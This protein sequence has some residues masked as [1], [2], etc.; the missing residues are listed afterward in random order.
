MKKRIT[1]SLDSSLLQ[2]AKVLAA[3]NKQSVSAM[4]VEILETLVAKEDKYELHHRQALA[5]ME[6]GFDLGRKY[7]T[8]EQVHA[9][10]RA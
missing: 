1:L 3:K 5:S 7:L 8:R 4:L 6:H 10:Q 2:Q 9:R